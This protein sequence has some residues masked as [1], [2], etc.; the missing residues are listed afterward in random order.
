MFS[1]PPRRLKRRS[2]PSVSLAGFVD[3]GSYLL[4]EPAQQAEASAKQASAARRGDGSRIMP[5]LYPVPWL[6]MRR[7]QTFRSA[8]FINPGSYLLSRDLSS[9]YHRRAD[10]SL[11]GSEWVRV[12]P[13]GCDHQVSGGA[14]ASLLIW[15]SFLRRGFLSVC[16]RLA[17]A[18]RP[19][20]FFFLFVLLFST[21]FTF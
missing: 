8:L 14:P 13:S 5:R 11:P 4:P 12:G 17:S 1:N 3:P 15:L 6:E 20:F 7:A 18:W 9:D 21:W 16:G 19:G 2:P 10:V